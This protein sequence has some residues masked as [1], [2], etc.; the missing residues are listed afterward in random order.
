[1]RLLRL[2]SRSRP[3]GIGEGK[4]LRCHEQSCDFPLLSIAPVRAAGERNCGAPW[5]PA[6]QAK[7]MSG[8]SEPLIGWVGWSSSFMLCNDALRGAW[9]S[10]MTSSPLRSYYARSRLQ[11][12]CQRPGSAQVIENAAS[13]RTT[14]GPERLRCLCVG[15]RLRR[16]QQCVRFWTAG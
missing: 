9:L 15:G 5:L 13:K 1:M 3:T 12:W 8:P 7:R 4:R 11:R 16:D 10:W 2:Q 14:E 6:P